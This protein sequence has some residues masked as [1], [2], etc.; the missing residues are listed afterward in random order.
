MCCG[1]GSGKL[2]AA[3]AAAANT[4]QRCFAFAVC[5]S[6]CAPLL[7]PATLLFLAIGQ[8]ML[9]RS[10]YRHSVVNL[11]SDGSLSRSFH[12]HLG[13]HRMGH[14]NPPSNQPWNYLTPSE[15][16][17]LKHINTSR[18]LAGK[19]IVLLKNSKVRQERQ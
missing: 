10:L 6:A 19:G 7:L 17:S 9:G 5:H 11:L 8:E 13:F 1:C 12:Y 16:H 4:P 2:T 3:I 14:L 15:I 18:V